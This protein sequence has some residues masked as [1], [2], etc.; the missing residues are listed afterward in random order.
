MDWKN[1]FSSA[2]INNFGQLTTSLLSNT[3]QKPTKNVKYIYGF[4]L[5][6]VPFD[7]FFSS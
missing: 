6:F 5:G 7:F 4:S 2:D 3:F 1:A